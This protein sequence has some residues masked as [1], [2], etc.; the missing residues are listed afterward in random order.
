MIP[1]LSMLILFIETH[2]YCT[3]VSFLDSTACEIYNM[4]C[5]LNAL[6]VITRNTC[7]TEPRDL[8][9]RSIKCQGW[10]GGENWSKLCNLGGRVST[11]ALILEREM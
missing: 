6:L 2:N 5:V 11:L 1:S 7:I 8:G 9:R 10:E 4:I 3:R